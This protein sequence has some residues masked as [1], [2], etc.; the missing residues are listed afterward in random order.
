MWYV[1]LVSNKSMKW[2][3]NLHFLKHT[4]LDILYFKSRTF[5]VFVFLDSLCKFVIYSGH[6]SVEKKE[7][8]WSQY[9]LFLEECQ[10]LTKADNDL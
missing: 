6:K 7:K 1:Y 4:S 8:F 2:V 5:L 9:L 10:T 3:K